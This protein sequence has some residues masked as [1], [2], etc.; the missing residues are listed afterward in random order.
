[1]LMRITLT[2]TEITSIALLIVSLM[3]KMM[4]QAN[5]LSLVTKALKQMKVPLLHHL[6]LFQHR[7]K[8]QHALAQ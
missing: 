1:M 4:T 7:V 8:T 5:L 2:Q 6:L 3:M